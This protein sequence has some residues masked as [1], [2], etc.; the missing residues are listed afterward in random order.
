MSL[1]HAKR[2]GNFPPPDESPDAVP[3]TTTGN[4]C[5]KVPVPYLQVQRARLCVPSSTAVT[6]PRQYNLGA[7]SSLNPVSKQCLST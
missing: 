7:E 6:L 2:L 4:T 3:H 1:L 5:Y